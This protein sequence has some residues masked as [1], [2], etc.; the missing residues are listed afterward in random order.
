MYPAQRNISPE[1]EHEQRV[2]ALVDYFRKQG[3]RV[4]SAAC[5]GY[6]EPN[7]I[8][9]HEPDVQGTDSRGVVFFGEVKTG[10]GDIS[11]GHSREQYCDFANRQMVGSSIPCPLYLYVPNDALAELHRVLAQEGLSGRSNIIILT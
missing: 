11:S 10:R 1:D 8:G 9:R 6:P 5:R 2:V 3:W 7:A 4:T